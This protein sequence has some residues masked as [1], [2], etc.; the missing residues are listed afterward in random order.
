[1][2]IVKYPLRAWFNFCGAL[3]ENSL[4]NKQGFRTDGNLLIML[5]LLQASHHEIAETD[6]K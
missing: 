3:R 5:P 4:I 1:V 6:E 2:V